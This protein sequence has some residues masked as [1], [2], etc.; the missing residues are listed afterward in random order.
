MTATREKTFLLARREA[1][2]LEW[3]AR[4]LP[5]RI[6]PDHL[7]VLGVLAA[8]GIAAAYCSPTAI[9]PGC[10]PRARC[11]SCTGSATRSTAR[12]PACARPSGRPTATTSTT[13][14]TRS[15]PR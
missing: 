15:P 3:I 8:F 7:T 9:R 4:R 11:S 13:S 6:M 12:S 2:V 1:R 10:G 14:S 5:A